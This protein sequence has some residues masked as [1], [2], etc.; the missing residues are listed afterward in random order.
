MSKFTIISEKDILS[1]DSLMVTWFSKMCEEE[2]KKV[3]TQ[4][5]Q[6]NIWALGSS[7]E[8]SEVHIE[9][10]MQMERYKVFLN[11]LLKC[12]RG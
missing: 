5:Y 1:L 3:N 12:V 9:N 7:A 6:E 2:I 11:H 10:M 8:Q 4:I